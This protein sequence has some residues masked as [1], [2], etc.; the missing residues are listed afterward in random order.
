MKKE[1]LKKLIDTAAGRIPADVVIRNCKIVNVFSGEI[2]EG[3]IALCGSQIAGI[4]DYEGK[5][6][7]DAQG[8]YAAPGFIDSHIHIESAYV[9]PEEF[10]LAPADYLIRP[11][12]EGDA[13]RLGLR[14]EKSLK[15][16]MMEQR[17]P[18][19]ERALVPV[20]AREGRPAAA[21]GLGPDRDALARPGEDSIHITM[22]KGE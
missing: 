3:D 4:G 13:L 6:V 2:T 7:V 9:S 15:K 20:L 5:E 21:G 11:R 10:Y 19:E 12:R 22:R 14:P 18:R 16:L 17:V 8:R 1:E